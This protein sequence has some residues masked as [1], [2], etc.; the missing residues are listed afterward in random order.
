MG[1]KM[2]KEAICPPSGP[3]HSKQ[4]YHSCFLLSKTI[5]WTLQTDIGQGPNTRGG[6]MPGPETTREGRH[7]MS[8]KQL[9]R[10]NKD[11]T[12]TGL[13]K[14]RQFVA[15]CVLLKMKKEQN[16]RMQCRVVW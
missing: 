7:A 5:T 1:L 2:D 10:V 14:G 16:S 4:N 11:M 15:M 13:C 12:N 6:E 8:T 3:C 9:K